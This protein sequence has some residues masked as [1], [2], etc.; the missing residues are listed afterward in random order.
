MCLRTPAW[1]AFLTALLLCGCKD[2]EIKS[3][4]APKDPIVTTPG[5]PA[6]TNAA[7]GDDATMANTA[8]PTGSD[9]FAWTAPVQWTAKPPSPMRKGSFAIKGADGAEA[10]F[11][12]TAFPGD[13]GGLLANLNRW[14]T[15]L[16]LPPLTE[17]QLDGAIEHVDAN[18]LHFEV[19]DFVGTANGVP[20]RTIGAVLPQQGETW[21]FKMMG[22]D[23]V[24]AGEKQ[25]F[26]AFLDT[27]KPR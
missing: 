8:V 22:P 14:R 12:I 1:I 6:A 3:Y 16:S 10:D 5:A 15:Q 23:A 20:T 17:Q 4:R 18:G 24:V 2:R 19:V 9:R 13:T 25:A 7:T 21:F 27:V 11:S 26:R